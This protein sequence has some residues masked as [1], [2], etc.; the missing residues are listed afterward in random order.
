M[1][2][3]HAAFF[4]GTIPLL[5]ACATPQ[6]RLVG[7]TARGDAVGIRAALAKGGDVNAAVPGKDTS[8]G[9]PGTRTSLQLAACL[10]NDGIVSLLLDNRANP[11]AVAPGTETPLILAARGGHREIVRRLLAAHANPD[12]VAAGTTALNSSVDAEIVRLLLAAKAGPEVKDG[13]GD[14]PLIHA[15]KAGQADIVAQLLKAGARPDTARADGGTPLMYAANADTAG[16]LLA[17]HAKLNARDEL[18]NDAL[19][20]AVQSGNDGV[21][22]FLLQHGASVFL[23]N[24][25]GVAAVDLKSTS[26][27][28]NQLVRKEYE[29]RLQEELDRTL[30]AAGMATASGNFTGALS[31]YGNAL[32]IAQKI[33]KDAERA[34]RL[35]FL[36][37][38][39]GWPVQPVLPDAAHEHELRAELKLKHNGNPADA[40]TELQQA[41][42]AAPWWAD[43][44]FNLGLVQGSAGEYRAAIDTLQ[45]FIDGSPDNPR[46]QAAK[47]KIVEFKVAQEELDANAALAGRWSARNQVF[48][49]TV[50]G[51]RLRLGTRG[52]SLVFDTRIKDRAIT[53]TVDE[54]GYRGEHNCDIPPQSHPV[55][56]KV[57]ADGRT[58]ELQYLRTSFAT[59]Y[60]CATMFNE[61]VACGGMA[62]T[63]DVCQSVTA[64][65]SSTVDLVLRRE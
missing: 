11:D 45:V 14:T 13:S 27:R 25:A 37:S 62:I 24:K 17:A 3:R 52:N 6:E 43:G 47:D 8:A 46:V 57:S 5:V 31:Q 50:D 32:L 53:G 41:I 64:N 42:D 28:V 61:I 38:V 29:R 7:A 12:Q 16:L 49:A 48:D 15:A 9:C 59:S 22:E 10:G 1:K 34:V 18:G 36:R 44:Y 65:G 51:D 23:Q 26:D 63:H 21:V 20:H 19:F 58:I 39:A 4:L 54:K 33:G 56:G 2:F 30:G 40:E 35:R 55:S 60:Q